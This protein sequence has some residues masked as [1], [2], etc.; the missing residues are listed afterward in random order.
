MGRKV[1]KKARGFKDPVGVEYKQGLFYI[2]FEGKGRIP[3]SLKGGYTSKH[4][5]LAA[6]QKYRDKHSY[7]CVD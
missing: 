3:K 5:C 6:I 7:E 1:Y 2:T 4:R